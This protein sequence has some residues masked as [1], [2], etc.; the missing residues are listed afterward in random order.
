MLFA[1]LAATLALASAELTPVTQKVIILESSQ[2]CTQTQKKPNCLVA[3]ENPSFAL[4]GMELTSCTDSGRVNTVTCNYQEMKDEHGLCTVCP[5]DDET[6][7]YFESKKILKGKKH[8]PCEI[9]CRYSD[10]EFGEEDGCADKCAPRIDDL[11]LTDCGEMEEEGMLVCSYEGLTNFCGSCTA[12]EG[13]NLA[14]EYKKE[15][16]SL[17]KLA[18]RYQG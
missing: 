18:C 5:T 3:C 16:G 14:N 2:N 11:L 8:D 6:G 12:L 4:D 15:S 9:S 1:A 17:C 10:E 7:L 13:L